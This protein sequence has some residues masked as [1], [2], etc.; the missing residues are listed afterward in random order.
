MGKQIK[1]TDIVEKDIFKNLIDSA[2][3]SISKLKLMNDQFVV[4]A[5]TIKSSMK[6]AK[7]DTTKELNEFIKATKSATTVSKEQVKVMQE[8]EKANAL[9]AKAQQELIRVEKEQLK[10]Q[11]QAIKSARTKLTDDEKQEKINI[12]KQKSIDDESNAYKR[13]EKNTRDL[14]NQSK[15]LG[16]TLLELERDGKKNTK[17]F[18][19]LERKFRD[20]TRQAQTGDQALKKLDKTVG[21]NFRNVGNY[22]SGLDR[23]RS[24]LGALGIAFGIGTIVR[25]VTKTL[26]SFDEES[27][28][29]SKTL[30]VTIEEAR[31]LSEQLLKI[32]T[33]TSIE[34]LQ[35]IA[36]I[37]G[38]LGI[39]KKE[40]VGFTES[41]DKLN[42]ALGDEFTGGAEEI[43]SVVGGL[44]NVFSDI[45]SDD[46]SKDLLHIGNA[47]NVL[48][49]E[50]S[51][52]SPVMADFAS[53]IGGIGIPLGLS[54]G[55]VLGLSATLQELNVNAE[56]GGTAV[57]T[58]LKKMA[59]DTEGFSQ[60]AGMSTKAF[61][62][63]VNTDLMG[64]FTKV[65]EGT[66]QFKGNAVGLSGALDKLHLNGSGASEVFLK[67]ADNTD[68]LK[69]RTD[70]GTKSLKEE[71]SILDEFGK[72]NETLQAKFDKLGKAWDTYV[73]GINSAGNATGF[74]GK[75][76]DFLTN[77]LG[78]II[79]LVTKLAIGYG[80]LVAWSNI[81]IIKNK[82]KGK[83]FADLGL[84]LKNAVLG[85]KKLGE[86]EMDA[87]SG[88]K[89]LGTALKTI[90]FAIFI[91][92]A[93]E[94]AVALYDVASGAKA[95]REQQDITARA[96]KLA[97]RNVSALTEATKKQVDE[98]KRLV[99]LEIRNRKAKGEDAKKLDT[100]QIER[101]RVLESQGLQSLKTQG[102]S[103]KASLSTVAP[104][105]D[106]INA[107]IK[108]ADTPL[109][110]L[111]KARNELIRALPRGLGAASASGEELSKIG[112]TYVQQLTS[113]IIGLSKAEKE[114]TD[115]I[116]ESN[117][118][119]EESKKI[120]KE[121]NLGKITAKVP[122]TKTAI[123][124]LDTT[125]KDFNKTLSEQAELLNELDNIYKNRTIDLKTEEIKSEYDKQI[126][127][128]EETG[129]SNVVLLEK[130]L[131]EEKELKKKQAEDNLKFKLDQ[132]EKEYQALVAEKQ[133]ELDLEKKT[134]LAQEG[135]TPGAKTKIEANYL[136]KQK[137]LNAELLISHKDMETKKIIATENASNEVLAIAT[138]KNEKYIKLSDEIY[139][140]QKKNDEKIVDT[141]KITTDEELAKR[142][143]F[144]EDVNKLA[145][146]SAD[147]FIKQ[148]NKKIAQAEL[149]LNALTTQKQFLEQLAVNGN[150]T[151]E[152]SLA[153]NE[154]LTAELNKKKAKEIK[155]QE[156]IKL[157]ESVFTSYT[158]NVANKEK[159]PII[160]TISDIS[161]LTAFINS[162][163][164]FY[165]GTERTVGES[166]G[167]PQL[168]GRDGHIV[169]VDGSEKILNPTLSKMTGNMTTLEIAQLAEDKLRGKI[170]A[171]GKTNIE[172]IETNYSNDVIVEKLDQLNNTI[173]NKPEMNV[174]VGE[175]LGGVMHVVEST[176]NSRQ[177]VRNI[178]RFS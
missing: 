174:E 116:D 165:K 9:K 76:V 1:R 18:T 58:I 135:I 87:S 67:L 105:L 51:A 123:K 155:K 66:R 152:K 31:L 176:K 52:T 124:E 64:A 43:T 120:V 159:N 65:V 173:L 136:I 15:Q 118:L 162:L 2:D 146:M 88:A 79:S 142:K 86:A 55:Q 154:K 140:A 49:A 126:I 90:G 111:E 151:A 24:G 168:S 62:D 131:D 133:K 153:Q 141:T 40:I 57:G 10:L 160:K 35:K 109:I 74:F 60:L 36:V 20:V 5:K 108:D 114:Y 145:Q 63:L 166:L 47:L 158:A 99:D 28:N 71:A 8:L 134:L 129:K 32:D 85:T 48:G 59:N 170:M 50:G 125:F 34:D 27:A 150:I 122:S 103:K 115:M 23:L 148:S 167:M 39:A 175:I 78:T 7:F 12:R 14:K 77:N 97:E 25:G 102:A 53:R 81:I 147:Y 3:A 163:P 119:M 83:S 112:S 143:Q 38:Q 92:L 94:L 128:A 121:D 138:D 73:L 101:N 19:D 6:T 106:R 17:E 137:E 164:T 113:E 30:G 37:G 89:A 45:K 157:A 72:K 4:M 44:R 42:V 95:A 177:T 96:N 84:Y 22:S 80:A 161:V 100:E 33:R 178:T 130:L 169:R 117:V 69:L 29:I 75:S 61:A 156:R 54:T 91:E 26:T 46:V 16:A 144:Y 127:N 41:I 107:A 11:D 13:L 68:L 110:V 172:L 132:L 171:K 104:I 98:Q 21:D 82:L 149:E 70:Q 56:R 93:I 139:E